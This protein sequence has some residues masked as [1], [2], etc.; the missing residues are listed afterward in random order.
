MSDEQEFV[1]DIRTFPA[2]GDTSILK[3]VSFGPASRYFSILID[4]DPEINELYVTIGNG[5]DNEE[6]PTSVA[7]VLTQVADMLRE[8]GQQPEF[9]RQL[10]N[11]ED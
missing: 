2:D 9:W 11:K 4:I 6:I 7:D 10:N 1:L 5:P 3:E 8:A